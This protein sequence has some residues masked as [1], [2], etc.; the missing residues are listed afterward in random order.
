MRHCGAGGRSVNKR[1]GRFILMNVSGVLI[2][3]K[4]QGI[5]SHAVVNRVRRIFDIKTVGHAGT[6]D[7]MATGVLPVL[8][9][10]AVKASEFLKEHNKR[11]LAGV[12][13]GIT[14]DS[15]DTTGNVFSRFDGVTPSF[16]EFK[17]AALSFK[18]TFMQLPPM[19]SALKVGGVKLVKLARQGIEVER[20]PREVTISDISAKEENG[21]FMIDVACS[22]GTYIRSLC[23]DIGKKLG[24]GAVMSSLRRTVVGDFDIENAYTLE[25][26]AEMDEEQLCKTLIPVDTLF[27]EYAKIVLP[28]FFATLYKNGCEIYFKKLRPVGID[29]EKVGVYYRVYDRN[30]FI[31]LG[32]SAMFENGVALK[33]RKMFFN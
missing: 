22:K 13:L 32:E 33:A 18:G 5:S 21:E 15:F 20:V 24:C 1:D 12:K 3:D 4:P 31:A 19:Y 23:D 26:L 28:D 2:I 17:A 30:G 14:T 27:E 9:G 8:V 6:L 10:R 16:E 25:R 7:P 11:Y 29:R